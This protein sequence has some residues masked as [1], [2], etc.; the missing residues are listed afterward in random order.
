[1][2]ASSQRG[3]I[4]NIG[5][6]AHIDAGKTTVSERVLFYSGRL[7][8][9]AEVHDGEAFFD[10]QPEEKKHGITITS[11]VSQFSWKGSEIYLIDTPGHVDFTVEVERSL[12]V[13][14]GVVALYD[15]VEGVEPQ[16]ETVWYQ[17]NRYQVPRLGF[18]NKMDR[19]GAS[20]ERTLTSV[21]K[22]LDAH[23]IPIQM[24]IGSESRFSGV[25]DLID[26]QAITF[27]DHDQG[28]NPEIGPIPEALLDEAK[29]ARE[30]MIELIADVNDEV[31]LAYLEG[32]PLDAETLHGALRKATIA[33]TAVP[34]LCGTG[35]RNKGI[36][37]LLDA[38]VR[39][40]P[41][42][43]ELPAVSGLSL[44]GAKETRE[45]DAK[46]AF[47]GLI[48]KVQ[49]IEGQKL[50]F[51]RI[52]SGTLKTGDNIL[53][54]TQNVSQ[55][56]KNLI[57]LHANRK[58][59]VNVAQAGEIIAL[60]G[61]RRGITGDTFCDPDRPIILEKIEARKPV[62]SA[63]V[64]PESAKDKDKLLDTLK[65]VAE[66]DPTFVFEE[67]EASGELII[68]G[69]GELHLDIVAERLEREFKLK[70]RRGEPDVVCRETISSP[71]TGHAVFERE[72]DD[73]RIYGEVEVRVTPLERGAGTELRV[74]LPKT[75][76]PVRNDVMRAVEQGLE[77]A[78]ASGPRGHEL[79]DV[80]VVVIAIAPDP[81]ND[82]VPLG[83]RIAAGEAVR[84][85]LRDA[86][87]IQL[88][89]LMKVE[90]I[91]PEDNLGG[92]IHDLSSRGGAVD[93]ILD[94]DLRKIVIAR[95]PLRKMFGYTTA[96]RSMTQGRG[97]FTMS[98]HAF[99]H[100]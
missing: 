43:N 75:H 65:L 78:S 22:K 4:R 90:I 68:R 93:D 81:R 23:P 1:M 67:D 57:H 14:D 34:F 62:I 88:E 60:A 47:A 52:Y 17:A 38:V 55:R 13:L 28:L 39:Y 74:E 35:L 98:F 89:P 45:R 91:V 92:V 63:A 97:V 66:E 29:A 87:P 86:T 61:V 21:R 82:N 51:M 12:R 69:M 94:D 6:M 20:F 7:H 59:R 77:D 71:G 72:T 26:M 80:E 64:E 30:H 50:A 24:P 46:E 49:M 83:Y 58:K 33:Q 48:F 27:H 3:P 42:P 36:Q 8:R 85:A 5:I 54:T 9:T 25:I 19:I 37:P 100:V 15:A 73:E 79:Q 10:W 32:E 96:L 76:P 2:T 18:A 41:A 84:K 44:D 40:L 11:A 31:A 99:D 70:L 53:N 95:A 16:S 56:I